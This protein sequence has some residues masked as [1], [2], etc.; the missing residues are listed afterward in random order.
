MLFLQCTYLLTI[1]AHKH[2]AKLDFRQS[3]YALF[4]FLIRNDISF[5]DYG[6]VHRFITL[7]YYASCTYILCT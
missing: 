6:D 3:V 1:Y 4:F 7:L 5:A 2:N